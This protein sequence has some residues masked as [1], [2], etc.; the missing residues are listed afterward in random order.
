MGANIKLMLVVTDKMV[1][2]RRQATV[3]P[4]RS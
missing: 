3:P 2:G 4:V 1:Q